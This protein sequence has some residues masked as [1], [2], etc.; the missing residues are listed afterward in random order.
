MNLKIL[1]DYL[2]YK[3]LISYKS[4]FI[5]LLFLLEKKSHIV[6]T[7]ILANEVSYKFIIQCISKGILR[8]ASGNFFQY[9][10]YYK[11]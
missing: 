9:I 4:E 5:T 1:N 8:K 2:D 10:G 11:F 7:N 6:E 3:D